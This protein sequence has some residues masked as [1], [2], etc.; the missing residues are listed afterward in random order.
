MAF[1]ENIR[2]VV[3]VVTGNAKGALSSLR[4]DVDAAEGSFNKVKT[5]AGGMLSGI[6]SSPAALL[7]VGA[8]VG[9]FAAKSIS[10]FQNTALAADKFRDS[11]GLSLDASSRWIAVADDVGIGADTIQNAFGKMEKAIAANRAAFGDLVVT[12]KDGTVDLNATFLNVIQHIQG[13]KDPLDRAKESAKLFGKGFAEVSDIIGTD[14]DTLREKLAAVSDAQVINEA[15]VAKARKFQ[16]AMDD[17]NDSVG[18]VERNIGSQLVPAL[19]DLAAI[20]AKTITVTVDFS[21]KGTEVLDKLDAKSGG[22]FGSIRKAAEESLNP[23]GT[24]ISRVRD[25]YNAFLDVTKDVGLGTEVLG[26]GFDA[27]KTKSQEMSAAIGPAGASLDDFVRK[28]NAGID[29]R[30]LDDMT[31]GADEAKNKIDEIGAAYDLLRGKLSVQD[32]QLSLADGFDK[33]KQSADEWLAASAAGSAD[34]SKN[35]RTNQEDVVN[36]KQKVV[37]YGEKVLGLPPEVVSN[38]L[39]LIDEGKL[40]DAQSALDK[41]AKDREAAFKAKPLPAELAATEK[42]F[43]NT[44]RTRSALMLAHPETGAA[45]GALENTARGRNADITAVPH[46]SAAEAAINAVSRARSMVLSIIPTLTG[47]I[48]HGATGG[49]HSGVTLVGE[50]GPELVDL[51][52][53]SYIHTADET[54]RMLSAGMPGSAQGVGGNNITINLPV[55]SDPTATHRELNRYV[56]RNGSR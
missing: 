12:A 38:I 55:G 27:L 51:P 21:V 53:G 39:A 7:G 49:P 22:I 2:L 56:L 1:T 23:V 44:A 20:A 32:A 48:P 35:L 8:A 47:A 13:I 34:V 9:A 17:L 52:G 45:E 37:E 10:Q 33:V 15:E 28:A 16:G 42:A 43:E 46:T 41:A 19:A 26:G 50:K 5:A 3:D 4:A 40:A 24:A 31:T 6:A 25:S 30:W 14:A 54:K 11:T 18:D 29:S 36:L